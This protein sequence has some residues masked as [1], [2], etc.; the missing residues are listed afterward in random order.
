MGQI[1]SVE[2]L[3][4]WEAKIIF[5]RTIQYSPDSVEVQVQRAFKNIKNS[6]NFDWREGPKSK[7]IIYDWLFSLSEPFL[8][9][10]HED[11]LRLSGTELQEVPDSFEQARP[12]DGQVHQLMVYN[13]NSLTP[14][15]LLN[16][17]LWDRMDNTN[18]AAAVVH[19]AFY[20]FLRDQSPEVDSRRVRRAVGLAM[21]GY[22]FVNL[23]QL[24]GPG[25]QI[26]CNSYDFDFFLSESSDLIEGL[27][28]IPTKVN[29]FYVIGLQKYVLGKDMFSGS[30]EDFLKP[31]ISGTREWRIDLRN[32]LP[33]KMNFLFDRQVT[34]NKVYFSASQGSVLQSLSCRIL[35]DI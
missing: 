34:D 22:Q 26:W 16:E 3:D 20:K 1:T 35:I 14:K 24:L 8:L 29:K 17:D 25:K 28:L 23:D 11:I 32:S 15:I 21:S 31:S 5:Q 9:K 19:E 30:I 27:I 7:T 33:Q 13:D 12:A 18:K 2:V 6:M 4:L 10:V